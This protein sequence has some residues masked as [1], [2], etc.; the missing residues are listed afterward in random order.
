MLEE[1]GHARTVARDDRK[2]YE[3]TPEGT[4]ELAEHAEEVNEFYRGDDGEADWE[5]Y[6][7]EMAR[8][9]KRVKHCMHAFKLGMLR[10]RVRTSTIRKIR[11]ILDEALA[12]IE[13]LISDEGL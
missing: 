6:A 2:T 7:E 12:K 9:M 4:R 5:Q 10:G 13:D 1:L 11:A 8:V 3:I